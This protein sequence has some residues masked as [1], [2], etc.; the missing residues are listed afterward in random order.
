MDWVTGLEKVIDVVMLM[1]WVGGFM[2][3][4]LCI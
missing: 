1:G 3:W 4:S 2:N